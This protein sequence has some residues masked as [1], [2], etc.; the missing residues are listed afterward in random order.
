M[1][2]LLPTC[3]QACYA[4]LQP[5]NLAIYAELGIVGFCKCLAELQLRLV[6]DPECTENLASKITIRG[7][8]RSAYINIDM[9]C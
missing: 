8:R 7:V 3:L 6:I 5:D 2:D 4:F 1:L 9:Q